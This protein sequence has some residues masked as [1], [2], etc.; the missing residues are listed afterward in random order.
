MN[1]EHVVAAHK[2]QLTALQELTAKALETVDKIAQLNITT[3]KT[4][5][6][7]H[8]DHVQSL[9]STKDVKELTKLSKNSLH[10]LAE[11]AATYNQ[12]LFN[13]A[14]GLGSE[15]SQ[16]VETQLADAQSKFVAAVEA[17][18]NN[19]PSGADPIKVTVKAA[20]TNAADAMD[21]V[22]KAVK[23]ATDTNQ[24]KLATIATTSVEAVKATRK[25]TKAAH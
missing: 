15:F 8:G 16:L 24:A 13:I 6:D 10:D 21:N 23:Q 18:M 4:T 1:A 17:S 20:L 7:G 14:A 2:A 9:L 3:A 25:P 22:K 5:L 11:K 19:L 12:N